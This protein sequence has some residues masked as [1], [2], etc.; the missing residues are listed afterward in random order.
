MSFAEIQYGRYLRIV[1]PPVGCELFRRE[2][3][4]DLLSPDPAATDTNRILR[5]EKPGPT[6]TA[7]TADERVH[8]RISF[9]N[10]SDI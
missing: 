3:V 7:V 5:M 4:R 9:G 1:P 10:V 2:I 6:R 8:H